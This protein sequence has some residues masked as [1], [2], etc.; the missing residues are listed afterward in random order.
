[1]LS[2]TSSMVT[3]RLHCFGVDLQ[4]FV[5]DGIIGL[6]YISLVSDA[7]SFTLFRVEDSTRLEFHTCSLFKSCWGVIVSSSFVIF[8][9]NMQSSAESLMWIWHRMIRHWCK[10]QTTEGQALCLG[11][12]YNYN[13]TIVEWMCR[14][15]VWTD[16][17][18]FSVRNWRD[19]W[20]DPTVHISNES[21]GVWLRHSHSQTVKHFKMF[22][23]VCWSRAL[24]YF[25]SFFLSRWCIYLVDH[26]FIYYYKTYVLVCI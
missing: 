8:Q 19:R 17:V 16:Y 1:M 20:A 23:R 25:H 12:H 24:K 3:A 2:P 4:S 11:V 13:F 21:D 10:P 7:S 15:N 26:A 22:I 5:M 18:T 6:S 14:Y 9:C